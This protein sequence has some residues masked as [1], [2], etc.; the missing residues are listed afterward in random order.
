MHFIESTRLKNTTFALIKI[1]EL[2]H[3]SVRLVEIPLEERQGRVKLLP[4]SFVEKFPA[5][6][7]GS[8]KD[9]IC[10]IEDVLLCNILGKIETQ[11]E[12]EDLGARVLLND[13]TERRCVTRKT[14]F[15]AENYINQPVDFD[16]IANS[17]NLMHKG[18]IEERHV[19]WPNNFTL[20]DSSSSTHT[21][22]MERST[23]FTATQQ[24]KN[25]SSNKFYMKF[26]EVKEATTDSEMKHSGGSFSPYSE[27]VKGRLEDGSPKGL[28]TRVRIETGDVKAFQHDCYSYY[29]LTGE[30]LHDPKNKINSDYLSG[31]ELRRTD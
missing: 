16:D 23:I 28:W 5:A 24:E 26:I 18:S 29:D 31:F 22:G 12:L 4:D 8:D 1:N 20:R 9:I 3:H 25:R 13:G 2:E 27:Y 15:G 7:T 10:A 30:E 19:A 14:S 6:R 17:I 21:S 11:K